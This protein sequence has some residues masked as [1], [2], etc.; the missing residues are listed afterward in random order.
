MKSLM[1]F[2]PSLMLVAALL[3]CNAQ[4]KSLPK[5]LQFETRYQPW[6][7]EGVPHEPV[8][9]IF[10]V[11]LAGK[12]DVLK[13]VSSVHYELSNQAKSA[14]ITHR[15]ESSFYVEG[16]MPVKDSTI[17]IVATLRMKNG[18]KSIH[19]ISLRPR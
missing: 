14:R 10:K 8:E 9:Y 19:K 3:G 7:L 5:G 11:H 17:F 16:A 13:N 1:K 18:K 15:I 4:E 2:I 12:S 6:F